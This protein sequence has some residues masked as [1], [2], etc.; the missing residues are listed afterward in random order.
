M[1]G[2]R[3]IIGSFKHM[4]SDIKCRKDELEKFSEEVKLLWTEQLNFT[5]VS[6]QAVSR[7]LCK[8]LMN[9]PD[10]ETMDI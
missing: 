8:C 2:K 3:D 7:K 4:A 5:I 9:A 10:G 1:P 6:D